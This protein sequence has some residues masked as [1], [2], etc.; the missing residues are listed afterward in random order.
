MATIRIYHDSWRGALQAH[1][2]HTGH[3]ARTIPTANEKGPGSGPFFSH[4]TRPGAHA[5]SSG[6][7]RSPYLGR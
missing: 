6:D 4:T 2:L 5:Y 3:A 1:P 7:G